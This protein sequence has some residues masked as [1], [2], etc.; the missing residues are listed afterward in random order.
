MK[1]IEML[2]TLD[3]KALETV[4]ANAIRLSTTGTPKQRDQARDALPLIEA[5]RTRRADLVPAPTT[6]AKASRRKKVAK[7]VDA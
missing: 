7:P 4:L 2:P 6:P 1:I 5:E 3:A